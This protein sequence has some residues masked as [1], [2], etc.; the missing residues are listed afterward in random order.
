[1]GLSHD[2]FHVAAKREGFPVKQRRVCGADILLQK[3]LWRDLA[4][5]PLMVHLGMIMGQP[6]P[7]CLVQF[8][9]WRHAIP[10]FDDLRIGMVGFDHDVL[11]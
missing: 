5:G 9:G 8:R 4:I 1:M 3:Y 11:T 10:G 6:L 7:N 2:T